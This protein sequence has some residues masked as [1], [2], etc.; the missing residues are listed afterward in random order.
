MREVYT[1]D[2]II[3]KLVNR[4]FI[5]VDLP[6]S[7][8]KEEQ[9]LYSNL[10]IA[11]AMASLATAEKNKATKELKNS[12]ATKLAEAS[13]N[14]PIELDRCDPFILSAKVS[15]PRKSFDK[16]AFIKALAKKYDLS[17]IELQNLAKETVKE[18]TAPVSFE[19]TLGNV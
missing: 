7:N 5:A 4:A 13:P 8:R 15:N 19:I 6:D 14:T 3:T 2:E 11:T 9:T 17:M 18:S 12:F 10:F 16:D 1:P